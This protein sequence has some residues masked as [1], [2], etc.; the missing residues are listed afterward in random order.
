MSL[1]RYVLVRTAWQ[2]AVLFAFVSLAYVVAW[3][4]PS[5]PLGVTLSFL[6]VTG[7]FAVSLG[8]LFALATIRAPRLRPAVRAVGMGFV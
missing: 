4:V 5:K 8:T 6:L 2:I 7:V 1:R 3:V